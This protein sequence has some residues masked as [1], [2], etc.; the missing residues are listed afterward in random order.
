MD[1]R[2]TVKS[3]RK[4]S[5]KSCNLSHIDFFIKRFIYKKESFRRKDCVKK[6]AIS[7]TSYIKLFYVYR[8]SNG[9]ITSVLCTYVP[10]NDIFQ[11]A[12]RC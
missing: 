10:C 9:A 2:T 12:D 8:N 7:E 4:V 3:L 6:Y 5:E 11:Y 1:A